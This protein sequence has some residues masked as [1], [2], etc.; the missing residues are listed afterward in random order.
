MAPTGGGNVKVVVRV[1][2][3][4]KREIE[5]NAACIVEMKGDQTVL[6]P[7]PDAVEKA[8]RGGNKAIH[9]GN[10]TFKF[11]KSYWSF[12]KNDSNYAGQD[13]LFNDLGNPLLDNAFG[14]YNNCIFAYGQ[15]GSGKSYSMMGYGEEAGVIPKICRDMFERIDKMQADPNL[16]CTVEVSY[17]EI[18][19]ERVRDLLNPATKGNLRVR[20]HPSTGPYVEDLAKLAVRSFAE[21]ENLMDEGN[22]ARTVAATNMNETS[23]RSHAVF[24]LSL[25]QKRHDAETKMDT[26]KVAKISLVDLAGSERATSTGATGARLKEGAEINRS[27]ST[28]GRV[29]AALADL[30]SGKTKTTKVPYRDS[31]LTWLL[32]DSLGGNSMTAMIAAISPADINFEETL[33]TLRYADSAKRIKNH[34]VVNEDPNA[35]M[36]RELKEELAQLRS[37]LAGGG[38]S[39]GAGNVQAYPEGTPLE[40]QMITITQADGT[41]KQVS[42]AELMDQLNQSEKLYQD[43]NETWEEKLLK[44]EAIHKEREAALEELG[45]SI[46]KGNVGMSTPK[47]MPHLVNLSDDPLLAECLVYNLK[48][49]ITTVGNVDASESSEIRLNGS[50]IL[51][52][53]CK[54]ENVDN[55]VTIIPTE[56]AAVMVNGVRV[57]KSKRLRSGN[58]IILGDFHIFRFNNPLEAKAER[59]ERSLLRHSVTASQISSPS[60]LRPSHERS[61]STAGSEID[62]HSSRAESPMPGG[63]DSDWSYARREAANA[64]LGNDTRINKLTDEELDSLFENIQRAR[65]ERR[66]RPILSDNDEDSDENS[67]FLV[68][69]KYVSAGTMDGYSLDTAFSMPGTPSMSD[70]AENDGDVTLKASQLDMQNQ[71]EEQ[72]AVFEKQLK[73]D[74]VS[75]PTSESAQEAQ[76]A[77]MREELE[78]QKQEFKEELRKQKEEFAEQKRV[79]ELEKRAGRPPELTP[80]ERATARLVVDRWQGRNNVRIAEAVLQTAGLLKEAQ[81]MSKLLEQETMFQ[82]AILDAGENHGSSYDLILHDISRDEDIALQDARKPCLAVRVI[83]HQFS[84]IHLWSIEKLKQRL[85]KMRQMYH[86]KDQPDY[87][88]HFRLDNPF[89]DSDQPLYSLIGDG[90]IPLTAVFETRVQDFNVDVISPFTKQIIGKVRMSLEP[91]LAESPPSTI[92]F[93]IVMRDFVG[94]SEHEGTNVHAQMSVLGTS[95]ES[96]ATTHTVSGFGEGPVRFESIHTLSVARNSEQSAVLKIAV[97]SQVTSTHLDKL[98]SWDELRELMENPEEVKQAKHRIPESEFHTEERYDVFAKVQ[99]LELNENGQYAPVEVVH[100]DGSDQGV[101]QLHQGLQRRISITLT[102]SLTETLPW[103]D[104]KSLRV[105]EVH[106]IDSSGRIADIGTET[107]DIPLK[108]IQEPMIKDNADGTSNVTIIGQWDSSLHKSLL[109]DRAT[110][111]NCRVQV[112]VRWDIVSSRLDKPMVFSIPQQVQITPRTYYRPQSVLKSFWNQTRITRSTEG[113]FNIVVRPTSAKRAAD[114]WRMDTS[115]DYVNGEELVGSWSPR[116]ISLVKDYISAR[117]K[118]RQMQDIESAKATLGIKRLTVAGGKSKSRTPSPAEPPNAREEDLLRRFAAV[119]SRRGFELSHPI[120]GESSSD[121]STSNTNGGGDTQPAADANGRKI[122]YI[123][124]VANI[125]KNPVSLKSGYLLTP[126]DT[127]DPDHASMQWKRRF[128]DLRSP[129][130]MIHSVP[131]GEAINAINLSYARIDHDPD[132]KRLLGGVPSEVM[133]GS[134]SNGK[135]HKRGG[136][137][138]LHGLA[139]VFAVYGEQ[140]TFLFAARSESQKVDWILRIDQSYFGS[141]QEEDGVG[142]S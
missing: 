97:F 75:S 138:D 140:N 101:F 85:A 15:T 77:Q 71:L 76:A 55:I 52:H 124:A 88:Q 134:S 58:R 73:V 17:L 39:L 81:V 37:K 18:Y 80:G 53:H 92:K 142:D 48:P 95:D 102:Q 3:F 56:G 4:N 44:T 40:K 6:S 115:K 86:Y 60:P 98:N 94:F 133:D 28:L 8:K 119:W 107:P 126:S 29:I 13:N 68:R 78:R 46:E 122:K 82:F 42:K 106:L 87:L 90:S 35:R 65:E 24:T 66:G 121:S 31:V 45:I 33:S 22:K 111:E 49:G 114:L 72:K 19:N 83:D 99:F 2:P 51:E 5:R 132:F 84:C 27:L 123:A 135:G 1:R 70:G 110:N 57:E 9:E 93:N 69:D 105:G 50:K 91:S 127:L 108:Q 64:L 34:A 32:K 116:G 128:V 47:K 109:L 74:R 12:D 26:E 16:K 43:L 67:S 89:R 30:S 23:S 130:L 54:L 20:E 36:I 136:S 7:P 61:I 10:K 141:V 62:G 25:T 113:L 100:T 21:I 38:G 120:F 139:H 118:R 112:S 125:P 11:D 41:E 103:D 96:V 63:R 79:W 117:R 59:A 104:L 129:Y 131:D 137:A 14:G